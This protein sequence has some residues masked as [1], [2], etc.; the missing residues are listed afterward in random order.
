MLRRLH[1]GLLV[2][3][4]VAP[5]SEVPAAEWPFTGQLEIRTSIGT[6]P[7]DGQLLSVPLSGVAEI[8]AGVLRIPAGAISAAVPDLFGFGG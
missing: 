6:N 2:L 5:A 3:A 8:E 7:A 4:L 1:A